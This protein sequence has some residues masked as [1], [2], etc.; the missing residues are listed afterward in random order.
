MFCS[1]FRTR[2]RLR[3]NFCAM[4]VVRIGE[5]VRAAPWSDKNPELCMLAG[6]HYHVDIEKRTWCPLCIMESH[7]EKTFNANQNLTAPTDIINS[8]AQARCFGNLHGSMSV[9]TLLY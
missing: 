9:K 6:P 1:V 8:L 7:V 2:L 4:V 3:G 5:N